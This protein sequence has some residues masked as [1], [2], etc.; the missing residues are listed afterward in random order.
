MI[1][2]IDVFC[3]VGGLARGEPAAVPFELAAATQA[4]LGIA[5]S[6]VHVAPWGHETDVGRANARLFEATAARPATLAPCPVCLPA[7]G[8]GLPGE[9][10]QVSEALA[11]RAWAC[12]LRPKS[13]GWLMCEWVA[14][15]LLKVLEERRLPALVHAG[16]CD[17][18]AL[19]DMAAR[20]PGLPWVLLDPGY[21]QQQNLVPLLAARPNIM[22][23][24]GGA[25][26][27]HTGLEDLVRSVGAARVLFG[28]G[29][30]ETEPACAVTYLLY[31]GLADEQKRMIGAA[32]ARRLREEVRR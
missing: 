7:A 9:T 20:Y 16:E 3:G 26:A 29:L 8:R 18:P 24:L 22:L 2:L 31:S 10:A 15:P 12:L 5:E 21:R 4:R 28:T 27:V 14:G 1:E 32:N 25:Y 13:D 17:L 23:A 30:P 6:L 11:Q 19:A